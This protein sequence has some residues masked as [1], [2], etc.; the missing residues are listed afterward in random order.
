[1]VS[2]RLMMARTLCRRFSA[3]SGFW[4]MI[5]SARSWSRLRLGTVGASFGPGHL[6]RRALV[7]RAQAE[8]HPGQGGLPAARLADQ[9]ERLT[10]TQ[11]EIDVR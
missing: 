2:G 1:L 4:K 6:E 8:Q 10:D 11:V 5:C 9:A 3:E 7:G